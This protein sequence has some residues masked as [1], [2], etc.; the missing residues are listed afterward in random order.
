MN[1]N[2]NILS[3]ADWLPQ[4][5]ADAKNWRWGSRLEGLSRCAA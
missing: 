5:Q 4:S 3:G 2:T 1:N